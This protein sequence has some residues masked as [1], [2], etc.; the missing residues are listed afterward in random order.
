MDGKFIKAWPFAGLPC[1]LFLDAN[2]QM[3]LAT[4]FAGQI[5]QLDANGKAVAAMGQPGKALGEFGEAHYL[6]FAPGGD[7]YVAD[8]VKP[9][10][11]RFVRQ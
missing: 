2:Q 10:L 1:G 4:G 9:A 5:L 3:Y 6:T 11:H 8:T 7:I